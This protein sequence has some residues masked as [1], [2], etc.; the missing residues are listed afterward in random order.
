MF[1][2]PRKGAAALLKTALCVPF[3]SLTHVTSQKQGI[4]LRGISKI[5][6]SAQPLCYGEINLSFSLRSLCMHHKPG[7]VTMEI[8]GP[9]RR[10]GRAPSGS[11]VPV[12]IQRGF[13]MVGPSIQ[14]APC[15]HTS[16]GIPLFMVMLS[17]NSPH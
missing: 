13:H 11:C 7:T 12:F 2:W 14:P 3:T 8:Q 16:F 5:R 1:E 4:I 6:L 17:K 15:T 9:D 10:E